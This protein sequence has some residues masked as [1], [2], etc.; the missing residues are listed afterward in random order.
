MVEV[1]EVFM[2]PDTLG[3]DSSGRRLSV[4]SCTDSTERRSSEAELAMTQGLLEKLP[5]TAMRSRNTSKMRTGVGGGGGRAAG[6]GGRGC[7]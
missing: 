3:S 1:C 4:S 6:G 5:P 2:C 7:E